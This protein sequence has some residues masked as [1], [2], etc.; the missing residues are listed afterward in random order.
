VGADNTA[1]VE[2]P[3]DDPSQ[4]NSGLNCAINPKL[5]SCRYNQVANANSKGDVVYTNLSHDLDN[6]CRPLH[7]DVC[8]RVG[9]KFGLCRWS[10]EGLCKGGAVDDSAFLPVCVSSPVVYDCSEEPMDS[11]TFCKVNDPKVP[12]GLLGVCAGENLECSLAHYKPG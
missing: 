10:S 4:R 3:G 6:A 5:R 2:A 9:E 7:K 11:R 8:T 1:G 12:P